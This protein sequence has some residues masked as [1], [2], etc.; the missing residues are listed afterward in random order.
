MAAGPATEAVP[1]HQE[2]SR[3]TA[4]KAIADAMPEQNTKI[5]VASDAPTLLVAGSLDG[6]T[7]VENARD[8]AETLPNAELLVVEDAAH[9]LFGR[10]E[11][12]R[13]AL[14]FLERR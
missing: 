3:N 6:R 1:S 12:M 13:R 9:D 8:V 7:P 5:S 14:L 11:V 2:R 4:P 10:P